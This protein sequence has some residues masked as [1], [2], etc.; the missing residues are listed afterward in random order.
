MEF[1]SSV[2]YRSMVGD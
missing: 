2:V 1:K